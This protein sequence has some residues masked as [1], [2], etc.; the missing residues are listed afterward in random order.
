MPGSF[1]EY[2]LI[3][4][5]ANNHQPKPGS[6]NSWVSADEAVRATRAIRGAGDTPVIVPAAF[7]ANEAPLLEAGADCVVRLPLNDEKLKLEARRAL[8]VAE[9]LEGSKHGQ[10]SSNK[11]V[12]RGFGAALAHAI[13]NRGRSLK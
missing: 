5:A 10:S 1:G 3:I 2:Q 4:V 8:K 11:P 6:S 7:P 13:R 9:P 12:T